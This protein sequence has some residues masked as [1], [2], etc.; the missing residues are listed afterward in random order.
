MFLQSVIPKHW[1]VV[2]RRCIDDIQLSRPLKVS[3]RHLWFLVV[4]QLSVLMYPEGKQ[5]VIFE[6]TYASM[7]SVFLFDGSSQ[8][9]YNLLI[10]RF[11]RFEKQECCSS[12]ALAPL[13]SHCR[14]VE[15]CRQAKKNVTHWSIFFFQKSQT[16][17]FLGTSAQAIGE[18]PKTTD[19]WYWLWKACSIGFHHYS[20]VLPL[21]S[22]WE[23]MMVGMHLITASGR[24][25]VAETSLIYQTHFKLSS[26]DETEQV[27]KPEEQEI[28]MFKRPVTSQEIAESP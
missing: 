22:G 16:N 24:C 3:I 26:T 20:G 18:R 14:I 6:E 19:F 13:M 1:I 12:Y 4:L 21:F 23:Q 28:C 27:S 15:K 5:F 11:L 10:R 2:V 7:S 8:Q 17:Y 25:L 9:V